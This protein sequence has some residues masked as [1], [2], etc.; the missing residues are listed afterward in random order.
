[1]RCRAASATLGREMGRTRAAP[2]ADSS[3]EA[4][5]GAVVPP[6]QRELFAGKPLTTRRVPIL[7]L[8][9]TVLDLHRRLTAGTLDLRRP[10]RPDVVWPPAAQARLVESVL[11]R[12][13]LPPIHVVEARDGSMRLIDGLQR[14]SALF[15]FL[16]GK[17][18]LTGLRLLPE[19]EGKRFPDLEIRMRRRYEDAPLTV[20]VLQ[21]GADPGLVVD[22]FN[23]MNAWAP[24][25][26]DEVQGG[27]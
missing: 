5:A 15:G 2:E 10:F 3:G 7:K 1:M 18:A 11:L 19:L 13:P 4:N 27:D 21:S 16:E 8:E 17:L 26:D 14:L 20:M 23:R 22:L 6:G 25:R 12:I 24:L 9:R